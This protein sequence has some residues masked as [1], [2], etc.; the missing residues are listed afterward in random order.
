VRFGLRDYDPDSGRWTARDPAFFAGS[1]M[2]MYM[3]VENDPVSRTDPTGLTS[4]GGW[5]GLG[6]ELE[7]E[8]SWDPATGEM[9]ACGGY[10]VGLGF[11]G[12]IDWM[13]NPEEGFSWFTELSAEVAGVGLTVNTKNDPCGNWE[14]GATTGAGPFSVGGGIGSEGVVPKGG[15]GA[16]SALGVKSGSR[17]CTSWGI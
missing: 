6:L 5:G 14:V 9:G 3:Y 15:F 16:G 12:G 1:P 11:G 7:F 17:Y 13:G 2:N 4:V 10:G 8:L